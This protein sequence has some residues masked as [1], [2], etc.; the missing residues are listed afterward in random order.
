M[1]K[2]I[3]LLCLCL[4][5]PVVMAKT[6]V[7]YHTSDTHGF[8]Y[9]KNGQGG[10]AVL[11][12]LLKQ[13]KVPYLLLDSGDFAEGTIETKNSKGLKAVELMNAVGYQAATLGNHE[14]A[15]GDEALKKMLSQAK[16]SILAAN[17]F[18]KNSFL[19][20][21]NI[22]P[23]QIFDVEGVKIAVIGLA[24]RNPT[25]PSQHFVF[26]KPLDSLKKALDQKEVQEAHAVVV[27]AH[28]S[29][30]DDRPEK[31]FYMGEIG[32]K[33]A[34]QVHVVL[35]GHAHKVFQNEYVGK[36]LFVESGYHLKYVSKIEIETDDKTGRFVKAV[37]K[38]IPLYQNKLG[39][40][41]TIEKMA[42]E[43]RE[44]EV[45]EVLG[46]LQTPL[47]LKTQTK[48]HKDTPADNWVADLGREYAQTD[49]FVGNVGGVRVPLE[50]G[51]VTRRHVM[52]MFPFDDQVV[53]LQVDGR[54]LKSLVKNS[55][56]PRNL[57]SFSGL[58]VEY[59]NKKGKVKNLKIYVNGK[60]VQNHK[61]YSL[62]TNSY[63]ARKRFDRVPEKQT[64]KEKT[65]RILIEEALRKGMVSAPSSGRITE[66]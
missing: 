59:K 42:E 12:A 52:D 48:E 34:G 4:F 18:E 7:I 2:I 50:A 51:A 44:T 62:A 38:F 16:F 33:F 47:S 65:I 25:K 54:F 22:R 21:K 53:R 56:L 43:L 46:F 49:I 8:F 10:F 17:F 9:P 40:D 31:P 63:L 13:E 37:S 14:F 32:R 6:T 3:F 35:G 24:N 45:D 20:P 11:S 30:A 58:T 29:L 60:P 55:L 66:K 57:L 61:K 19:Y 39:K 36:V 64:L 26:A 1:K 28:D 41:P 5:S 15:Y 27:L 23:Y